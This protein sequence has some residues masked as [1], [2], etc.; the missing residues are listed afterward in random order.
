MS[1]VADA[2]HVGLALALDPR[3]LSLIDVAARRVLGPFDRT[4][5]SLV[6]EVKQLSERYTRRGGA[7][8][9]AAVERAARMRFFLPRDLPKVGGPLAELAHAGRLPTARRWRVLDL[10]AGLGSTSLGLAAFA[11]TLPVPPDGLD[12][13]AV[14]REAPLLDGM[15]ALASELGRQ[16]ALGVPITLEHAELDLEQ[17]V[18]PGRTFDL[19]LMGLSLNELWQDA[20]DA[21]ARRA[22]LLTRLMER[23]AADG[24]LIVIE[25]A[26]ATTTRELMQVRDAV[27]AEG[28]HV[29]APCPAATARCPLLA[30]ERDWCHEELPLS[31][32]PALASLAKEAGLR[33]EGLSYSYLTLTHGRPALNEALGANARVVG[34]PIVSK[35]RREL[36]LCM[37]GEHRRLNV[38]DR[39]AGSVDRHLS[40]GAVL[41]VQVVE[42][43][44]VMRAGRDATVQ[45]KRSL[46][47]DCRGG[48]E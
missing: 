13:L 5:S 4:G 16:P 32:P 41:D 2:H 22:N 9:D 26:L 12:V 37:D 14:E 6:H 19:V 8:R 11:R 36:H 48:R 3:W 34:G 10:G 30:R 42:A 31:L 27:V 45:T 33:F 39:D 24:S 29:F 20:P 47:V 38:L 28:A 46:A 43:R 21:I 44:E 7:L 40:R 1:A 17:D 25:P 15:R 23:V 18:L 35:G